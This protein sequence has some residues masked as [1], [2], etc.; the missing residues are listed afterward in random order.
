VRFVPRGFLVKSTSGK[1]SRE[2][3]YRKFC[4]HRGVAG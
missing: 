1:L 4:E 2:Q 3:S